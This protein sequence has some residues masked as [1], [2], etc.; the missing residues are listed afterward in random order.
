M[1][2]RGRSQLVESFVSLV[3]PAR[4]DRL[5]ALSLSRGAWP[6]FVRGVNCLV[7]PV[8]VCTLKKKR[9]EEKK[10]KV[11]REK[12]EKKKREREIKRRRE[13]DKSK[14]KREREN[15]NLKKNHKPK[16]PP[17]ELSHHDSKKKRPRQKELFGIFLRKFRISVL[18][19]IYSMIRIR[20]S[21]SQ[22]LIWKAF[23]I[24][25][26]SFS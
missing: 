12:R 3:P 16:N 18:F 4:I 1:V 10:R 25:R 2:L 21:G 8:S 22:E 6:F 19:S 14:T 24:A 20:F 7:I 23:S 11:K 13:Q 15:K 5:I 26:Y 17:D 9:E